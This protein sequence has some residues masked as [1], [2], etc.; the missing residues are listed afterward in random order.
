[1]IAYDKIYI[2]AS[3]KHAVGAELFEQTSA[4]YKM[5]LITSERDPDFEKLREGI[6]DSCPMYVLY[7]ETAGI[8][9][10]TGGAVKFKGRPLIVPVEL[11]GGKTDVP[12]YQNSNIIGPRMLRRGVVIGSA[13][14]VS[15]LNDGSTVPDFLILNPLALIQREEIKLDKQHIMSCNDVAKHIW[16]LRNSIHIHSLKSLRRSNESRRIES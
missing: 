13:G 8:K 16:K 11:A 5:F 14:V 2:Y 7:P 15:R 3:A 6:D 4:A 1:M 10:Y 9:D 12:Y